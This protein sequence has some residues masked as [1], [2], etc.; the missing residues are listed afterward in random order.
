MTK[1]VFTDNKTGMQYT[2][3]KLIEGIVSTIQFSETYDN[4]GSPGGAGGLFVGTF[5]KPD[6]FF[7]VNNACTYARYK[8]NVKSSGKCAKYVRLMLEAGGIDTKGHPVS[9]KDYANFLPKIGFKH[10]ATV[11]GKADQSSW[12]SSNARPGD[13]AV[14]N[15]G[16]HGHICM[17]TGEM[18]ASDFKQRNMWVYGG[19]GTCA[20]FRWGGKLA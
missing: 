12:T 11:H 15:H 3:E 9:A 7:H 17:Y 10:I 6:G 16:V 1:A 13:I 5:I 19:D 20:I 2:N 8:S 4:G 14:M 18:W